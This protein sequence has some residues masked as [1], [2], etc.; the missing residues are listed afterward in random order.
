MRTKIA[1][2]VVAV[3][4]GTTFA[5]DAGVWKFTTPATD[6][7]KNTGSIRLGRHG[8][9]VCGT[10]LYDG[11]PK[12][13]GWISLGVKDKDAVGTWWWNQQTGKMKL[14][15]DA[16]TLKGTWDDD[17]DEK[18]VQTPFS[19][20]YASPIAGSP[21]V[22]GT[23]RVDFDSWVGLV[24]FTQKGSQ[25]TGTCKMPNSGDDCGHWNA[26]LSGDL[27]VGAYDWVED[28]EKQVGNFEVTF[29]PTI[30]G[31]TLDGTLGKLEAGAPSCHNIG[32][33]RGG[34][35]KK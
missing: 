26:T 6:G 18:K 30:G 29:Q 20:S 9:V 2:A 23:Y 8:D 13:V 22:G 24:T 7:S 28:G 1:F 33:M 11:G 14:A 5:K 17:T 19:A 15:V 25:L 35:V 16:T 10:F 4:A 32:K 34:T 27:A 12:V 21:S 3:V 31:M